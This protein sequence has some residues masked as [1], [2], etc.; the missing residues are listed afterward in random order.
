MDQTI[1]GALSGEE[2]PIYEKP[3][4]GRFYGAAGGSSGEGSA[5][6]ANADR[7]NGFETEVKG[8]VGDGKIAEAQRLL[9]G[10]RHDANLMA[11]AN[12]AERQVQLLLREKRKLVED[13]ASREQ[14]RA[15]EVK[16][17]EA[18]DRLNRAGAMAD[19]RCS[20]PAIT[21][22]SSIERRTRAHRFASTGRA[23][24]CSSC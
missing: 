13:G 2:V 10:R 17:T 20:R 15:L 21:P 11:M 9:A 4:V 18:M 6:N 3:L 16:I 24:C 1:R 12:A 23:R 22:T 14:V 5:F 8:L 19:R 7:L